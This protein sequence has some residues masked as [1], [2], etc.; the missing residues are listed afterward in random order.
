MSS[1]HGLEGTDGDVD[2]D[3]WDHHWDVYGEAAEGNPANVYRRRLILQL[4]GPVGPGA[5]LLDIGSGQGEFAIAFKALHP[6]TD[7]WG[8]EYSTLGVER[9]QRA[10]A[11]RGIDVHFVRRDLLQP[12]E[13]DD[14]QTA[15]G[16]AVCSE[17]LEHVEDPTTLMRHAISLLAPAAKVVVTVPGGPRSAFDRHIGHWR[18]FDAPT[19]RR[20]L[21]ERGQWIG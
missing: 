21:T 20:V 17:V 16:W 5:T 18:H 9:S 19:L 11:R 13:S 6:E 3:D 2:P 4:L 7:V 15:A 14:A 8:V 10:A 1:T 12:V